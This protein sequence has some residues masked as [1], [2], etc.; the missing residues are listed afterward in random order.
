[1]LSRLAA[2]FVSFLTTKKAGA[3]RLQKEKS[4]EHNAVGVQPERFY[5]NSKGKMFLCNDKVAKYRDNEID[6]TVNLARWLYS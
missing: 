4:A 3:V 5:I 1:M 6:G 2:F